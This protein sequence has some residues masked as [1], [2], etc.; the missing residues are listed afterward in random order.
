ENIVYL[1]RYGDRMIVR[2]N[3]DTGA[4]EEVVSYDTG[5]LADPPAPYL[6]RWTADGHLIV[7]LDGN[8]GSWTIG[9]YEVDVRAKT[10]R[11]WGPPSYYSAFD[12]PF[13]DYLRWPTVHNHGHD[14]NSPDLVYW[15]GDSLELRNGIDSALILTFPV[16]ATYNG[17]NHCS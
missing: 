16:D 7:M 13:E 11:F 1:A 2:H 3:V 6:N 5:M 12:L 9:V 17:F 8:D 14:C 4:E 10:R 15:V